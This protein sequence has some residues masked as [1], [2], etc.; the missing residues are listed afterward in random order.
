M[1]DALVARLR[2]QQT[3]ID[4]C[5]GTILIERAVVNIVR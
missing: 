1:S 5:A 3:K 2:Y 4:G